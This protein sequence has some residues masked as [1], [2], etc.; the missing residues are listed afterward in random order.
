MR[1]TLGHV[2]FVLLWPLAWFYAPLFIRTRIIVRV[3]SEVLV[4]KNWFALDVWQLPGGG[5]S[6]KESGIQ[7]AKRELLE[8][9]SID[10]EDKDI[11]QITVEP[12]LVK[13]QGL[14]MRYQYFLVEF[15]NKPNIKLSREITQQNWLSFDEA[16]IPRI[17]KN[18]I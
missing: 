15:D 5:K 6:F 2:A 10:I 3:K 18:Q 12:I 11:K 1:K 4:V 16:P 13:S 17:I 14:L 7:A 8:E 9:L